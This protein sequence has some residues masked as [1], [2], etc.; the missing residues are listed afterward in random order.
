MDQVELYLRVYLG[1][2]S[3]MRHHIVVLVQVS[4]KDVESMS[5]VTMRL[6]SYLICL[7]S[8]KL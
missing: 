2:Y 3:Y 4:V 6:S 1:F 7:C 8:L 5:A